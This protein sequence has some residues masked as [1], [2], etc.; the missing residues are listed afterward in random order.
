MEAK[1]RGSWF[2]AMLVVVTLLWAGA[3]QA[4]AADSFTVSVTIDGNGSGSVNSIPSGVISCSYPPSAGICSSGPTP[5][6]PVTLTATASGFSTF[7]GWGGACAACTGSSCPITLD[8]A[9]SCSATF[10]TLAP[11][12]IAGNPPVYFTLL[13][14]A[15]AAATNGATIEARGVSIPVYLTANRTGRVTLKG[16]YDGSYGARNGHSTL[17]GNLLIRSG[18]VVLDRFS[19][20][21]APIPPAP[22]APAQPAATPGNGQV[23]L[24]WNSVANAAS[25]A[26]Y[27]GSSPGITKAGSTR[28][29][30]IA[31][32]SFTVTP[33]PNGA[34]CYFRIAA[35]NSG[36]EGALS[37]E[38][39]ATPIAQ[40]PAPSGITGT[41]G[42]GKVIVEW[43]SVQGATSYNLYVS[44]TPGFARATG[45]RFA[46]VTSPHTAASL[47]N[48]VRY[49]FVVT[50]V[51]AGGESLASNEVSGFPALPVATDMSSV[52]ESMTPAQRDAAMDTVNL[53][54]GNL[55]TGSL[56]ADNQALVA[57]IRTLPEFADA[58]I[59]GDRTVW[60]R[61]KDGFPV[62]FL[63]K[64]VAPGTVLGRAV[65]AQS[66]RKGTGAMPQGARTVLVDVDLL[67]TGA[68]ATIEPALQKKGYLPTRLPGSV[69]DFMS[70]KNVG[71]L[72]ITSHGG[73]MMTKSGRPCYGVMTNE[74]IPEFDP[75][76]AHA[77][78][79]RTLYRS[80]ELGMAGVLVNDSNGALISQPGSFWQITEKFVQKNWSFTGDSLAVLSS[81]QMFRDSNPASI[82]GDGAY[83]DFRAALNGAGAAVLLGWDGQV[84][85]EFASDA[86]QLFFDRVLGANAYQP[87]Q[88]PQRPFSFKQVH[89]WM[90][91]KGRDLEPTAPNARMILKEKT[92]FGQLAPSIVAATVSYPPPNASHA[93]EWILELSGSFFGP[94]V[95]G[96][97]AGTVTVGDTQLSILS[98]TEGGEGGIIAKLPAPM[99]RPGTLGDIVVEVRGHKSNVVPLTQ[100]TGTVT[101][102]QTGM[103][104]GGGRVEFSCPVSATADVHFRRSNPGSVPLFI[105]GMSLR[106]PT[107]C[108][109]AFSGAW[110]A[111]RY[112]YLLSGSGTGPAF[113]LPA[114]DEMAG[115]L[116]M[117]STYV[118]ALPVGFMANL[119]PKVRPMGNL[120]RTYRNPDGSIEVT[121]ST[122]PVGWALAPQSV[123][124]RVNLRADYKLTGTL[125]CKDPMDNSSA[126]CTESWNA[127]PVGVTAPKADTQS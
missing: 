10:T 93:G 119:D 47:N 111:G 86:M 50:A 68:L 115:T 81:C 88:P 67:S 94:K 24:S 90:K 99:G 76:D 75:A 121:N 53:A 11:V 2:C 110:S 116:S 41:S 73:E 31:G 5:A 42:D 89:D 66:A 58:G 92:T 71:V 104:E 117:S 35:A 52:P 108:S 120:K 105:G 54:W 61:F 21:A 101:Q 45:T 56:D 14:D 91:T 13:Q 30:D 95:T 19:I 106:V 60:A 29:G 63:T 78:N 17:Q 79:L 122:V 1:N 97:G 39:S 124:N 103:V 22:A 114:G 46:G 25:Y 107:A 55:H 123:T 44:L 113:L 18:T 34:P 6:G 70:I 36:G 40:P 38:Q 74:K 98:W 87:E 33:L 7:G 12:R 8:S 84:S 125:N 49:Y 27:Y 112:D 20:G 4:F 26:L 118:S 59:S 62:L 32:T 28:I 57:Y 80:G 127:T 69:D 85:P 72:L 9:K 37:P 83:P 64:T 82:T 48:D 3:V 65:P 126:T 43:N 102:V 51:N 109:Y 96:T 100:W 23:S 16:G 77:N 15:L